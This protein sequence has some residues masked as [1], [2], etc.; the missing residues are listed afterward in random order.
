[1]IYIQDFVYKTLAF[2][3][4]TLVL[5]SSTTYSASP[6][7]ANPIKSAT[8]VSEKFE[9]GPGK[10]AEKA[11]FDIEF[12][13]GHIG[14]KSFDAELVDEEGNSVPLYETYLH[15][16]FALRYLVK[17]NA[18][19]DPQ[20]PN[21]YAGKEVIRNAG[22]CN[23]YILPHFWGLGSESRGTPSKLPDPLAVELGNAAS[24]RPEY[25][26][27]WMF[28][29]MA[30]DTRGAE[31]KKGC[32][33]GKCDLFNLPKDFYNNTLGMDLKPLSPTY[34]G[35]IFCCKD[36]FQCKLQ[37]GFLAQTRKLSLRY[38][39]TWVDWNEFQ[40]PVKFY[41]LDSTDRV[42]RNGSTTIHDCQVKIYF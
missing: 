27:K 12:P 18:T 10:V 23:T 19:Q 30:I 14:V 15:H 2:V 1:M 22:T 40:V 16:W 33:E 39:I 20:N 11:F 34:E 6:G 17:I 35:G 26:E 3:S 32:T 38:K 37:K 36:G 4:S 29:L 41:V 13:R 5:L 31:N 28:N 9:L 24:T 25:E 42:I 21:P 7:H 8:F